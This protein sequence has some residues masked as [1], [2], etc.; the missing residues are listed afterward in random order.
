LT[1]IDQQLHNIDQYCAVVDL[2]KGVQMA[3]YKGFRLSITIDRVIDRPVN[4]LINK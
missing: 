2:Q 4:N 1:D 3:Q